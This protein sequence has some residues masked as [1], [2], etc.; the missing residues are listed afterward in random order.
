MKKNNSL[1]VKCD[2]CGKESLH[3]LMD[4]HFIEWDIILCYSCSVNWV[5]D[6]DQ[7]RTYSQ[8]IYKKYCKKNRI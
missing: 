6:S 7:F 8:F 2:D 4:Y 3:Y 1:Y 5:D